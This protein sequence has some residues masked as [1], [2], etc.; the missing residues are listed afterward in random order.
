MHIGPIHSGQRFT[1]LAAAG[2][3]L[4]G[5]ALATPVP[6]KTMICV[7]ESHGAIGAGYV[8]LN[9]DGKARLVGNAGAK[10]GTFTDNGTEVLVTLKQPLSYQALTGPDP[11]DCNAQQY[12]RRYDIQKVLFRRVDGTNVNK[13]KSRVVEMGTITDVSGCTPGLVTP[14][15][16]PADE[17]DAM[18]HRNAGNREPMTD[19]VGGLT[20]A[21]MREPPRPDPY[22]SP[23][24]VIDADVV[25]LESDTTVRFQRS[26]H[27]VTAAMTADRWLGLQMP[28]F[29]PCPATSRVTACNR[30]LSPAPRRPRRSRGIS[31][32]STW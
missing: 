14:Y 8:V 32:A 29:Q 17:E 2:L 6:A 21:G 11:L 16:S 24:G 31:R 13:G 15:G 22:T 7:P 4:V 27:V 1:R 18:L 19:V 10:N 20:L 25:T 12:L 30:T 26:G 9:S 3:V 28:G 5:A 23:Y